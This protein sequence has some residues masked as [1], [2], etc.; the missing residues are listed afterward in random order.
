[1]FLVR[2]KGSLC[3]ELRE[4]KFTQ[5]NVDVRKVA[6]KQSAFVGCVLGQEGQPIHLQRRRIQCLSEL[7][8]PV[9]TPPIVRVPWFSVA[10]LLKTPF[11]HG[12][13]TYTISPLR[14]NAKKFYFFKDLVGATVGPLGQNG[15]SYQVFQLDGQVEYWRRLHPSDAASPQKCCHLTPWPMAIC[16]RGWSLEATLQTIRVSQPRPGAPSV[17]LWFLR[18]PALSAPFTKDGVLLNP[19]P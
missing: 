3:R 19:D 15:L 9:R 5:Q 13:T 7:G 4:E 2:C 14:R 8:K 16:C 10:E 6:T 11:H 18:R 1:M 12:S 17:F